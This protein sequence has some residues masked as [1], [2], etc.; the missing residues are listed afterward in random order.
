MPSRGSIQE[1]D[2]VLTSSAFFTNDL[3]SRQEENK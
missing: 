3:I 1:S 2:D